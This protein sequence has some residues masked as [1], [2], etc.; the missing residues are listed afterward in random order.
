VK[1]PA[2]SAIP[3]SALSLFRTT[4]PEQAH[5]KSKNA[6]KRKEASFRFSFFL[7]ELYQP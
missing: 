4:A 3:P 5:G 1:K 2:L 6:E 7:S